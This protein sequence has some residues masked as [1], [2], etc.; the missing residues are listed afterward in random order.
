MKI[1]TTKEKTDLKKLLL[2]NLF[3]WV[4]LFSAIT[5][6]VVSTITVFNM[7]DTVVNVNSARETLNSTEKFLVGN[8]KYR[9][10]ASVVAAQ[11]LL[12]ASD[13]DALLIKPGSPES[14]ED[15]LK[16]SEYLAI[17]DML[18][19]FADENGLEFVYYYF[20]IDNYIQ[21]LI[22][23]IQDS[24]ETL[25]P[26]SKLFTIEDAQ[27]SAWNN[28]QAVVADG[29]SFI[30]SNGLITAYAPIFDSD[31]EVFA[32]VGVDI[33]DEKIGILRNQIVFLSERIES[34]SKRIMQ[35]I[36]AMITALLFLV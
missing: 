36:I 2:N 10:H 17:K 14:S 11:H 30:D 16:N 20:R 9:I 33:K 8:Y 21:P 22:D 3:H 32:L 12:T 6:L 31:G 1:G 15:W 5:I 25:T 13:L 19:R 34:L 29:E 27:R 26:S 24:F 28:K 35:L 4:F 7:T 23:N 18:V